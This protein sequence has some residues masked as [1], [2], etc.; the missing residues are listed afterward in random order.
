MPRPLLQHLA[1][2]LTFCMLMMGGCSQASIVPPDF[3]FFM[4][5]RSP[6]VGTAQHINIRINAQGRGHFEYYDTGGVIQYDTKDIVIYEADKVVKAR[7]FNVTDDQL[8]HLWEAINEN[9]FFELT[10]DY[11]M[12]IGGSYAF[13]LIEADGRR[14]Q[15]DNIGMEVPEIK[16]LVEATDTI[17]PE[18]VHL[19]YGKGDMP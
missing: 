13:I 17:M 3:E 1:I 12:A 6:E 11:R 15:V 4:D 2:L 8:S 18:G 10:A 5:V 16:A 7:E 19:E 14:H 9:R